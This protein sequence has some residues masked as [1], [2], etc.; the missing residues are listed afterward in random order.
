[1]T[2]ENPVS[3]SISKSMPNYVAT[4]PSFEKK[5]EPCRRVANNPS[6]LKSAL[7]QGHDAKLFA[8]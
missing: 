8:I 4:L 6:K 1:M 7:L 2:A 3:M 5:F